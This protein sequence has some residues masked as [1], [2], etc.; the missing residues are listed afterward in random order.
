MSMQNCVFLY[1][2]TRFV[3]QVIFAFLELTLEEKPHTTVFPCV[4]VLL[5]NENICL[6]SVNIRMCLSL[7]KGSVLKHKL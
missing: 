4:S 3:S 2:T 7:G 1:S 6:I 5:T